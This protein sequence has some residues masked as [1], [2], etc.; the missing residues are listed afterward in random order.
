MTES[1]TAMLRRLWLNV[2]L[3]IG[4][5]LALL[6]IP[7]SI[8]GGL[9]VYH[10]EIDALLSPQRYAVTGAQVALPPSAYL[11]KAAEATAADLGNLRA[12]G[13]RYPE[14]N[15]WPIRVVTRAQQTEPGVRPRF[16][17]VFLDPPTAAVLDVMEFRDSFIGFLHVF[18]EN[19]MIPQYSG[20]QIVGW[21]G[22]GM[23]IL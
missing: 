14:A 6:L 2:H 9:L 1:R 17:T 20:R 11:G 21:A 13:L 10:D 4:V 7:I 5:G 8:S 18:H 19:L 23:L 15:G 16:V 12:T 3:W 22:V